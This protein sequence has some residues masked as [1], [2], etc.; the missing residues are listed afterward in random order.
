MLDMKDFVRSWR[1]AQDEAQGR[2]V[3]IA[4]G[5]PELRPFSQDLWSRR[6]AL[7]LESARHGDL[8]NAASILDR[9]LHV[10]DYGPRMHAT[11]ELPLDA[12]KRLME[13]I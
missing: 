3:V 1:R 8:S 11:G 6:E 5:T 2:L 13:A 9:V 4:R 12:V 7:A 10:L